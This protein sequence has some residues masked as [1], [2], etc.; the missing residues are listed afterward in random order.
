MVVQQGGPKV[1]QCVTYAPR[2]TRIDTYGA[3]RAL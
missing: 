1:Y 2:V 3:G